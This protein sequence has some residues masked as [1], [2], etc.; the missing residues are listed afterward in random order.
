MRYLQESVQK[1]VSKEKM[2]NSII[3]DIWKKIKEAISHDWKILF[4]TKIKGQK[5]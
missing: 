3:F 2:A 1:S 4:L 5:L